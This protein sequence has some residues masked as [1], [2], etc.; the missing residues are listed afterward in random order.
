[1]CNVFL[2]CQGILP[3]LDVIKHC[4]LALWACDNKAAE[5]AG[6]STYFKGANLHD[7]TRANALFEEDAAD[8]GVHSREGV[9]EQLDASA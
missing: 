9:I 1:M 2:L 7:A 5:S 8:A 4:I 3:K 6:Y